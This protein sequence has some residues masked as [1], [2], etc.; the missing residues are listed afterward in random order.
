MA[1]I[2]DVLDGADGEALISAMAKHIVAPDLGSCFPSS[3]FFFS[4]E[5]RYILQRQLRWQR[6]DCVS[7][8][9]ISELCSHAIS[10]EMSFVRSALS[11]GVEECTLILFSHVFPPPP[12]SQVCYAAQHKRGSRASHS[13]KP[14]LNITPAFAAPV[15]DIL[16]AK[17]L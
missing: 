6:K 5:K 7:S 2:N 8:A 12:S 16:E 10:A 17:V 14:L 4:S 3:G 11:H 15:P 13:T 9:P 1:S